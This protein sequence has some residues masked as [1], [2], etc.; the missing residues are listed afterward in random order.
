MNRRGFTLVELLATVAV[1]A[2]VFITAALILK[3]TLAAPVEDINKIS[4]N[5]VYEAARSFALETGMSF[6]RSG[7][8]CVTTKELADYGYLKAGD[9][10]DKIIKIVRNN[11]T[12]VIDSIS[13]VSE[14][15]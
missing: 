11:Q 10:S 14:C 8:A 12:K 6:N 1:I 3:D 13:Y 4:D 7:F 2:V 15:R 5:S 9:V